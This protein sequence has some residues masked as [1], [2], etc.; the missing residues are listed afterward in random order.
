M[1]ARLVLEGRRRATTTLGS[2]TEKYIK[3]VQREKTEKVQ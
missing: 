1:E 2:D 3:L